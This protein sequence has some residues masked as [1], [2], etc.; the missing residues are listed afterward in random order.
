MT[1]WLNEHE[2][3][4]SNFS[5]SEFDDKMSYQLTG[6]TAVIACLEFNKSLIE[7]IVECV[8]DKFEIVISVMYNFK[9]L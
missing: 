1:Q 3:C 8:I 6:M 9:R 7:E 2:S 5:S 4:K